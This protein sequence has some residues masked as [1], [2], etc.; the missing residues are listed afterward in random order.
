[1]AR[2]REGA[3]LTEAHRVA[4]IQI[5][6]RAAVRARAVWPLLDP[7]DLDGST[8][9]WMAATMQAVRATQEESLTVAE[10]YLYRF[11]D[12]EVG[13]QPG[14]IVRP[15]FSDAEI[16]TPLRIN[17]PVMVK[18]AIGAGQTVERALS[19]GHAAVQGMAFQMALAAGRGMI[20]QTA[21]QDRRGGRYRRVSDGSPC[22]FC[23]MLVSRGPTYSEETA[24]FRAHRNCG[25]TAEI[26]YGE[27]KPNAKER[28][29][30]DSYN[31]A[32]REASL[33]DGRRV[34]PVAREGRTEDTIL[35][36]MRRNS[37]GLFTD[38]VRP[39]D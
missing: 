31:R 1:M 9:V 39:R 10:R 19:A 37:P 34:A 2:T 7:A 35:W 5:G 3:A 14:P 36:R 27:W 30:I 32:A 16:G 17:G 6:G 23:A 8:P 28:E 29:W 24:Y 11:R 12:V 21:R 25:C 33:V 20:D 4:Q 13:E 15:S 22:A 26:V 38:G 18:R